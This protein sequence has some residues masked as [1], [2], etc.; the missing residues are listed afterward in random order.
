M[1]SGQP[2]FPTSQNEAKI[3]TFAQKIHSKVNF[4]GNKKAGH[5]IPHNDTKR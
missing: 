1:A 3:R 2:H 4:T 5:K